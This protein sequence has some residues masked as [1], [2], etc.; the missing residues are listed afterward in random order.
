MAACMSDAHGLVENNA[1]VCTLARGGLLTRGSVD[2][3][4]HVGV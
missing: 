3:D 2:D 4:M 1:Q